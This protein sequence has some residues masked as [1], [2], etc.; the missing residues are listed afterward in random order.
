[1]RVSL[2]SIVLFA[3]P[4]RDAVRDFVSTAYAYG[5]AYADPVVV[6]KH[7]NEHTGRWDTVDDYLKAYTYLQQRTAPEARVLAWWDY[8]HHITGI[9]QRT[10]LA[11]SATKDHEHTATV[12]L[13]L[14]SP[15][16]TA[17]T[18]M[19]H[20]ADYVLVW[21]GDDGDIPKS[22]HMAAVAQS[23]YPGG[24]CSVSDPLCEEWGRRH[25]RG[26]EEEESPVMRRS[27]LWHAYYHGEQH[28]VTLD[29]QLFELV[30]ESRHGLAKI[31]RVLDVSVES[32]QAWAADRHKC[33]ATIRAKNTDN[34]NGD[35]DGGGADGD[36]SNGGRGAE[37]G[38]GSG[39]PGRYPRTAEPLHAFLHRRVPFSRR[40]KYFEHRQ[41]QQRIAT[42]D[43]NGSDEDDRAYY[44]AYVR[45]WDRTG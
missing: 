11:D 14:T 32:R 41:Q 39:C 17:H 45:G 13:M 8:G 29:P 6:F 19:R 28:G 5:E 44:D 18:L 38:G 7:Y 34:D 20:L 24:V 2:F 3:G 25:Q 16:V 43:G 37:L 23:V 1:M 22:Q 12:A 15:V 9:G 30:Y 27:F 36:A 21:C 26:G 10:S 42:Y 35:D 4:L 40:V 31:F 33:A